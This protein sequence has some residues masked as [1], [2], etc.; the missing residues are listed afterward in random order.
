VTFIQFWYPNGQVL[1]QTHFSILY[2]HVSVLVHKL[3][4]IIVT[5]IVHVNEEDDVVFW[6]S[7]RISFWISGSV[8]VPARAVLVQKLKKCGFEPGRDRSEILKQI[9]KTTSLSLR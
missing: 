2:Q 1:V 8:F 4:I 3:T 5:T 7:F 9:Q 6:I